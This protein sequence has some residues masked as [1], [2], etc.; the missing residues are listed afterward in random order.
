MFISI[1]GQATALPRRSHLL[2]DLITQV[3]LR[4]LPYGIV[5]MGFIDAFVCAHHQHRRSIENP[6]N[7]GDCMKGRI[8]F[9]TAI[10]SAYAHAYQATCLTRHMLAVPRLNF[11]L[12]ETEA[13]HPHLPNVRTTTREGGWAVYTD[14]GTRVVNYLLMEE[15]VLCLVQSSPP[16][17]ISLFQV[18]ELTPTTPLK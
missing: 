16:R 5:V 17:L 12:P 13:I 8:R 15:L 11:R 2:L 10:T 3:F 1:W 6:G 9:M 18:P 14:G 7:F 4:S